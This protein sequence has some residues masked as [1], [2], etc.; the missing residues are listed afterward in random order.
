MITELG[1]HLLTKPE[2]FSAFPP[3]KNNKDSE[4]DE[5]LALLDH[6]TAP[7]QFP[8]LVV[9]LYLRCRICCY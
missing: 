3:L 7:D 4:E 2:L 5:L 8:K 1:L 9:R 6:P